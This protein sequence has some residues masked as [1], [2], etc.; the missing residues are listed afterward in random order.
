MIC[1]QYGITAGE[2]E[3][4][5]EYVFDTKE[6][7]TGFLDELVRYCDELHVVDNEDIDTG[8]WD[9]M[10]PYTSEHCWSRRFPGHGRGENLRILKYPLNPEVA[11]ILRK[12]DTFLD[13]G[14]DYEYD[15]G[16]D[17]AFYRNGEIVFWVLAHEDM[18]YLEENAEPQF[19][20]TLLSLRISRR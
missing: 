10:E 8:F 11:D 13:I 16:I 14:H 15:Q 18:C 4:V 1:T 9:Q 2:K 20:D 5:M 6:K 17:M 3:V 19:K 7:Y 12:Y